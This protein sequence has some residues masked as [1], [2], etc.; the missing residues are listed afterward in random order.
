MHVH[1]HTHTPHK[2]SEGV[3]PLWTTALQGHVV[4][5]DRVAGELGGACEVDP[6]KLPLGACA[7]A[8]YGCWAT[9]TGDHHYKGPSCADTEH[10]YII[11]TYHSYLP[12]TISS[13]CTHQYPTLHTIGHEHTPYTH[14]THT[15]HSSRSPPSPPLWSQGDPVMLSPKDRITLKRHSSV[16][17]GHLAT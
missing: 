16:T 5:R 13:L 14:H 10:P 8:E 7:G 3:S 1:A 11:R 12:V 6:P 2:G 4:L 9:F 17:T 15:I